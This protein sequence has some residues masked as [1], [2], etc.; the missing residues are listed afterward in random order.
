M[1]QTP[2]EW[3]LWYPRLL[4]PARD[5][6]KSVVYGQ[7]FASV[8]P[9]W[10]KRAEGGS[11]KGLELLIERG[12]YRPL[13][14]R[15]ILAEPDVE[16]HITARLA[17]LA[18]NEALNSSSS[19]MSA[20][21]N[22]VRNGGKLP[23]GIGYQAVPMSLPPSMRASGPV[24]IP[25]SASSAPIASTAPDTV[26]EQLVAR[27]AFDEPDGADGPVTAPRRVVDEIVRGAVAVIARDQQ[28][29]VPTTSEDSGSDVGVHGGDQRFRML[30]V[31]LPALPESWSI[32]DALAFRDTFAEP[33]ARIHAQINS[34]CDAMADND[35]ADLLK[36]F[37]SIVKHDLRPIRKALGDGPVRRLIKKYALPTVAAGIG[38][39]VAMELGLDRL[40]D[41]GVVGD[42][43]IEVVASSV[44]LPVAVGMWKRIGKR[45]ASSYTYA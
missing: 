23:S 36:D 31:S 19:D 35:D 7:G 12:L 27:F 17:V 37:S 30:S 16:Q 14:L 3:E 43:G 25:W 21:A 34:T 40:P 42:M 11:W 18:D 13:L 39:D 1:G 9:S 24:T 44:L 38:I 4:P 15:D 20:W 8:V 10:T 33:L 22:A 26:R 29:Y 32:E 28:E 45:S 41:F 2:S 5:L 6:M